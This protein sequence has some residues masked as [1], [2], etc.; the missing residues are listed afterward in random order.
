MNKCVKGIAEWKWRASA[1][2]STHTWLAA[3]YGKIYF[4]IFLK[5]F[6]G[7]LV[8]YDISHFHRKFNFLQFSNTSFFTK[9]PAIIFPRI[10][11]KTPS[12]L[13]SIISLKL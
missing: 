11:K 6:T 4:G 13:L 2:H 12:F 8:K 3:D 9:T 7:V 10:Y 5:I 1:W